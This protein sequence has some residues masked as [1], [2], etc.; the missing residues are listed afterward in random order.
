MDKLIKISWYIV[1]A[2]LIVTIVAAVIL[3]VSGG[4]PEVIGV[5]AGKFMAFMFWVIVV[6]YI[7]K[8]AFFRKS[9]S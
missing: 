3:A 4:T 7:L 6:L 2:T 9:K 5:M 1:V 8:F